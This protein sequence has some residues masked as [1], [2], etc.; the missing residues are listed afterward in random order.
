MIF[1]SEKKTPPVAK[2]AAGVTF[3]RFEKC[4]LKLQQKLAPPKPKILAASLLKNVCR[5][6][7]VITYSHVIIGRMIIMGLLDDP[8]IDFCDIFIHTSTA[9]PD[10][11]NNSFIILIFVK[12]AFREDRDV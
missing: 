9:A 3:F 1:G 8:L 4:L 11:Q 2:L 5:S 12:P 10:K 6:A 7:E